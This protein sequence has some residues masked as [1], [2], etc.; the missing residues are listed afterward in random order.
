MADVNNSPP[1]VLRREPTPGRTTV[2]CSGKVIAATAAALKAGVKPLIVPG[3]T[4]VLDL[5]EVGFMDSMGLGTIA[6]LW[7]S[8]KTAGCNFT[9]INFS[10]R[11]RDLFTVTHLLSLFEPCGEANAQIP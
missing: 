2:Y 6:T 4:L 9:L 11:L 3:G 1:L 10:A 8:S 7:V 5:S